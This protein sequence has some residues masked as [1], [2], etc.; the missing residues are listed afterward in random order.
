MVGKIS[1]II[2]VIILGVFFLKGG[3]QISKNA[4]AKARELKDKATSRIESFQEEQRPDIA[5]RRK[6]GG[7]NS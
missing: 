7:Q 2:G 3:S 1:L 5:E 6:M 4:L